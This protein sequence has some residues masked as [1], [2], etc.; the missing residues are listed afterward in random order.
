MMRLALMALAYLLLVGAAVAHRN[1]EIAEDPSLFP[2]EPSRR[3]HV[4]PRAARSAHP[5]AT[6]MHPANTFA[7]F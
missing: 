3:G 7:K 4:S 5:R 1:L 2:P 6:Y